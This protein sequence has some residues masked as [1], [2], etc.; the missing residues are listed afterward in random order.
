MTRIA[1]AVFAVAAHR[2]DALE[3]FYL[4]ELRL[5]GVRQADSLRMAAG[6]SSLGFTES[7]SDGGP[8]YHF[9]LLVPGNRFEAAREWIAAR[10]PLLAQPGSDETTFDFDFWDAH[11]CYVH[12]PA[13]NIVELIA[14][15]GLGDS[16]ETGAFDAAE[17]RGL[18]EVGIVTSDLV[19]GL[20]RL[21]AARL[22]LWYGEVSDEGGGLGFV[23]SKAHTL[24][25]CPEGRPWLPTHR[26]AEAHPIDVAL[27]TGAGS[28][29][30]IRVRDGAVTVDNAGSVVDRKEPA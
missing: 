24:V 14:H 20:E 3:R 23:G 19:A 29:L 25:L 16:P 26:P 10:T 15:R 7:P 6:S 18:S 5:P 28:D 8:F 17:L 9:A 22:E 12:D 1:A 21:R 11:A 30:L 13:G 2:L 27:G 4:D